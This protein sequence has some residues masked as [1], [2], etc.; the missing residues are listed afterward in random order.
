MSL[1]GTNVV[2][3]WDFS[4][5]TAC[6]STTHG[7]IAGLKALE[8]QEMQMI[9]TLSDVILCL[10]YRMHESVSHARRIT[11]KMRALNGR[12]LHVH[13]REHVKTDSSPICCHL[14]V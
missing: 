9:Y 3:L 2:P 10:Q 14:L 13:Q 12:V 1:F 5:R 8:A 4:I 11:L 6:I 7:S